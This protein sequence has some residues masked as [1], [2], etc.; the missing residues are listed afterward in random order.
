MLTSIEEQHLDV[1]EE[2]CEP[3]NQ[4]FEQTPLCLHQHVFIHSQISQC[5]HSIKK[6]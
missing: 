3:E 1:T 2:L 4:D 6:D 5:F